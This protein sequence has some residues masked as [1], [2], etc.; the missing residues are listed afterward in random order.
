[1]FIFEFLGKIL[2]CLSNYLNRTDNGTLK[3]G[4]NNQI[5]KR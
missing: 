3:K 1:M 2:C 4:I 5:I